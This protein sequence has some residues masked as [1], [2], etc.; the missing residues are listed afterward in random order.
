MKSRI[1]IGPVF[2]VLMP[3]NHATSTILNKCSYRPSWARFSPKAQEGVW[4]GKVRLATIRVDGTIRFPTGLLPQIV[5]Y[6]KKERGNTVGYKFD[7]KRDNKPYKVRL[8]ENVDPRYYQDKAT[9]VGLKKKRGIFKM[10][11]GSGKTILA[12]MLIDS[13]RCRTI[14]MTHKKDILMQTYESFQ[15]MLGKEAVGIVGDGKKNWNIITCCM[16]QTLHRNWKRYKQQFTDADLLLVDEVHLA[17]SPS[18]YNLCMKIQAP[19]RFGLTATPLI[20]S[21]KTL[22][23]AATG[24]IIYTL[25][26]KKLIDEG[27]LSK[28]NIF[29][30]QINQQ[31]VRESADYQDAYE[32]G[33]VQNPLRN[34]RIIQLVR[35]VSRLKRH[36]PIVIQTKKIELLYTL[37]ELLE[38]TDL[39]F[40]VLWGKDSATK[41]RKI[42]KQLEARKLHVLVVSTIFDEGVDVRNIRTL[43]VASGGKSNEKTIQRLGRGM[44]TADGKASVIIIDFYDTTHEY[45]ERHSKQRIKAYKREDHNPIIIKSIKRFKKELRKL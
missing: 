24:P 33:I 27:Y 42:V 32:E 11:T 18:W 14:F 22:L 45:L 31:V 44:R 4:D 19:W 21:R 39:K 15:N 36:T 43:I 10:P 28:P 37:K 3:G 12:G 16:V 13:L 40:E 6:L 8:P 34:K 17:T 41:R 9:K 38:E 1:L 29:M 30:Y 25:K 20:D 26:S 7:Y 35:A 2:S 5:E 23:Q